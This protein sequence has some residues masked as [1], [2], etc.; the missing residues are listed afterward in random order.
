MGYNYTVKPEWGKLL[1]EFVA[2][3]LGVVIRRDKDHAYS[4]DEF[5]NPDTNCDPDEY[6]VYVDSIQDSED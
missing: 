5:V 2:A 4:F 6:P 3:E 1:A